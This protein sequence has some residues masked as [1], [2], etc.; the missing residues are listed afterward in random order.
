M[1]FRRPQR[2]MGILMIIM[3]VAIVALASQ[4]TTFE[5]RN[6]TAILFLLPLGIYLIVTKKKVIYMEEV[7]SDGGD[8]PEQFRKDGGI[9][10]RTGVH[11][12]PD[13]QAIRH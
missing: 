10:K 5:E 1:D 9:G 13:T 2:V 11:V 3:C 8:G 7:Q 12:F 4:G 6:V